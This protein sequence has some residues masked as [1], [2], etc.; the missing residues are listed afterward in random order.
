MCDPLLDAVRSASATHKLFERGQRVLV[1]VSGGQDSCAL[2]HALASLRDEFSLTL[3]AAHVNHMLRGTASDRDEALVRELC[4]DLCIPVSVQRTDI[5]SAARHT[6]RST[7]EA[8]RTER[9]RFLHLCAA[10]VHADAIAVGHTADDRIETVLLN[11]VRGT[12]I[13]GLAAMP[14]R[15]G[16]LIRPLLGVTRGMTGAYCSRSGLHPA[17]DASNRS[18]HYRRNLLRHEVL[19]F[20][21]ARMNPGVKRAILDLAGAAES[22]NAFLQAET[23]RVIN[24]LASVTD[25]GVLMLDAEAY[26]RLD[27]ALRPLV[28]L[29]MISRVVGTHAD[30]TNREL[31]RIDEA[32]SAGRGE[33]WILTCRA[34]VST[35]RKLTIQQA[36]WPSVP[37]P[38]SETLPI[39][40]SVT[41]S[42]RGETY[43][44]SV[45]TLTDIPEVVRPNVIHIPLEAVEP[46][47]IIRS[48]RDGD[49]IRPLGMSGHKKVRDH[50]RDAHVPAR[51]RSMAVA[52]CDNRGILWIPGY[53]ADERARVTTVPAIVLRL[54]VLTPPQPIT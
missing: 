32:Q 15:D 16:M 4:R 3:H 51:A 54:E 46:P 44:A 27:P 20:L 38:V 19:P 12:G 5:R 11:I 43:T 1:A 42:G 13:R 9:Q 53:V 48:I 6:R 17:L 52:L 30:V 26:T 35:G 31:S 23:S 18:S 25:A 7:Q 10:R 21:E 40:G 2:T 34:V 29:A 37:L 28:I 33:Q 41:L 49:R 36:T 50:L 45:A 39:G 14:W 22:V 8:A 24:Q 47:V